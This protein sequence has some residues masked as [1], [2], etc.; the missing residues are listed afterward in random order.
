MV[1]ILR[2]SFFQP[3]VDYDRRHKCWDSEFYKD[4]HLAIGTFDLAPVLDML[5]MITSLVLH[6]E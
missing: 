3:I 2:T 6:K 4:E 5:L 1:S